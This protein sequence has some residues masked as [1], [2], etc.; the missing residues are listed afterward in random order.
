MK[1]VLRTIVRIIVVAGLS[2]CTANFGSGI[3]IVPFDSGEQLQ[4]CRQY[5]SDS[6]CERQMWG[7]QR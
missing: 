6:Y 5:A 2:A 1:V 7:G 4:N 3:Q